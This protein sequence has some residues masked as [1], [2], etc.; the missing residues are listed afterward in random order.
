MSKPPNYPKFLR[1]L[2]ESCPR[3]PNGVHQWLYRVARLLRRYHPDQEVHEILARKSA[4][5]GR[6]VGQREIQE[7]VR[8]AGIYKWEPER[9]FERSVE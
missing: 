8:N 6:H 7:T 1:E 5:C 2:L 4:N 3:S 9:H